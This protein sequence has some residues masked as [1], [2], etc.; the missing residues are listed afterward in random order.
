MPLVLAEHRIHKHHSRDNESSSCDP[1]QRGHDTFSAH[2]CPVAIW[3]TRSTFSPRIVAATIHAVIFV[4]LEFTNSPI[5][6]SSDVNITSGITANESW[7]ERT[8]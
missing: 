5:I 6:L 4:A 3:T 8:T 1:S 7:T 2:V